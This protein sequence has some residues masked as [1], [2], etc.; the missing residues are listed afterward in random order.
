M[1]I[2]TQFLPG[3]RET[4]VP[5]AVGSLWGLVA[6]LLFR[7]LPLSVRNGQLVSGAIDAIG[8]PL[9][10]TLFLAIALVLGYF[11]QLLVCSMVVAFVAWVKWRR[12]DDVPYMEYF[13][14]VL[15]RG[16]LTV[17]RFYENGWNGLRM[18]WDPC[19]SVCSVRS[20]I[21]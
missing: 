19:S 15:N 1:T 12:L 13:S 17:L 6:A 11:P 14:Q 9:A 5:L 21:S 4:R 7:Y 3:V 10:V 16:Y 18:A 8:A 20:A 2:W